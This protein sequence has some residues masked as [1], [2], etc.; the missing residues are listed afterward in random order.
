MDRALKI[1]LKERAALAGGHLEIES[2]S[3]SGTRVRAVFP[4]RWRDRVV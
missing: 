1:L 4:L 3:G 2:A